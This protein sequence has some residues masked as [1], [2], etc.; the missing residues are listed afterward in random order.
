MRVNARKRNISYDPDNC[1]RGG[2]VSS[3]SETQNICLIFFEV[4]V[5]L[6]CRPPPPVRGRPLL[7]DTPPPS[8]RTSLMDGPLLELLYTH[9]IAHLL[10][11]YCDLWHLVTLLL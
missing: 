2:R 1:G 7:V 3:E 6:R 11:E 4:D 10:I 8:G 9:S 5:L